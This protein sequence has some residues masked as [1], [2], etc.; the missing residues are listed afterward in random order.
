MGIARAPLFCGIQYRNLFGERGVKIFLY[1]Q[2]I[3]FSL[4]IMWGSKGCINEITTCCVIQCNTVLKWVRGN[5]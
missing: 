5:G 1:G 4:G 3:R 2:V